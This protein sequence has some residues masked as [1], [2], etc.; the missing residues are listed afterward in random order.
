MKIAILCA[1]IEERKKAYK[2]SCKKDWRKKKQKQLTNLKDLTL[3]RFMSN[4]IY[5]EIQSAELNP[6]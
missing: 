5:Y 6:R 3:Y 1:T 4:F 2:K